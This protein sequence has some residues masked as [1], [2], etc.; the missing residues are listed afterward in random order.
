[1]SDNP[2]NPIILPDPPLPAALA[3]LAPPN[4]TFTTPLTTMPT[5]ATKCSKPVHSLKTPAKHLK[6]TDHQ[7]MT[8]S[9]SRNALIN[10]SVEDMDMD[11]LIDH[12]ETVA[13]FVHSPF[14]PDSLL[15][16]TAC[17]DQYQC[18]I[19][20]SR[21]LIT[22]SHVIVNV[23]DGMGWNNQSGCVSTTKSLSMKALHCSYSPKKMLLFIIVIIVMLI[24]LCSAGKV[25]EIHISSVT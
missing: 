2:A 4:F 16:T 23:F 13:P 17:V 10:Q 11:K 18:Y 3:S 25:E 9:M 19:V 15:L 21:P 14:V 1:M 22:V 6:P 20:S 12:S 24:L 7:T 8:Q 5:T